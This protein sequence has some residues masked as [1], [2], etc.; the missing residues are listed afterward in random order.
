MTGAKY[1]PGD[2]TNPHHPEAA[3]IVGT[4]VEVRPGVGLGSCDL[5]EVRYQR[6]HDGS[7]HVM[8]FGTSHLSPGEPELLRELA[9]RYEELAAE[10]RVLAEHGESR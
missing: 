3:M 6:P 8:P 1:Q 7:V 10:M 5:I 2:R 4:V 9:E